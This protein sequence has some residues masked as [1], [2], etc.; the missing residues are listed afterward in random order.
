MWNRLCKLVVMNEAVVLLL[1]SLCG[2]VCSSL[3]EVRVNTAVLCLCVCVN[4]PSLPLLLLEESTHNFVS[5]HSQRET[6]RKRNRARKREREGGKERE[7]TKKEH[8]RRSDLLKAH[9]GMS[10]IQAPSSPDSSSSAH[11]CVTLFGG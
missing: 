8:E 1:V 4:T 7:K 11:G 2:M 10:S 9:Q 5:N 3:G 6:E